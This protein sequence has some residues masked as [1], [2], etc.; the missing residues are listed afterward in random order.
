MQKLRIIYT[1]D[2][3]KFRLRFPSTYFGKYKGDTE[4]AAMRQA[5]AGL[6]AHVGSLPGTVGVVTYLD[7]TKQYADNMRKKMAEH[8]IRSPTTA[9]LPLDIMNAVMKLRNEDRDN[10]VTAQYVYRQT[11]LLCCHEAV[12]CEKRAPAHVRYGI[13]IGSTIPNI[14]QIVYGYQQLADKIRHDIL[15]QTIKELSKIGTWKK[16]ENARKYFYARFAANRVSRELPLFF[17]VP[18]TF[19]AELVSVGLDDRLDEPQLPEGFECALRRGCKGVKD[20]AYVEEMLAKLKGPIKDLFGRTERFDILK[21][22]LEALPEPKTII[23]DIY[24]V[25]AIP[26]LRKADF[27]SVEYSP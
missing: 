11:T 24:I 3:G 27:E 5:Y 6:G 21:K 12:L 14:S 22:L 18:G 7:M 17:L 25:D 9:Y 13:L 26:Q 15:K 4:T 19:P 20:E 16:L 8:G 1:P 23:T 2:A 10:P